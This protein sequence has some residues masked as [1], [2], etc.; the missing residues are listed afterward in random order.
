MAVGIFGLLLVTHPLV[1]QSLYWDTNGATAG[2]GA[3]PTGTWVNN[4]SGANRNWATSIPGTTSTARWNENSTAL[5][6]AGSDATGGYTVTISGTV[7]VNGITIEEGSPTFTG[8]TIDFGDASPDLII[9]SGASLNWGSTTLSSSTGVLDVTNAG[10]LNFTQNLSFAGTVNISGGTL[11]LSDANVAFTTL[12]ITGNTTLDFAGSASSLSLV[13]FNIGAGVTLTITN[14]ADA[15]DVFTATN[16]AGAVY[17]TVGASP[18]NQVV[19]TGTTYGTG[20][21]SLDS[22]I[23]PIPE[24]STYGALLLA[25]ITGFFLWRRRRAT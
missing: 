25:A 6:S 19:F 12:N 15:V 7:T 22:E 13:N 23:R 21:R 3:A 9:N 10:A 8:G 18:M 16:W 17:D 20:W 5:F 2:A 1:G 24:P 14:W 11:R 4:N